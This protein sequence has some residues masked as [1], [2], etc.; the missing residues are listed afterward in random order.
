[1]SAM[2][3]VG[4]LVLGMAATIACVELGAY[5]ATE[6][7]RKSVREHERVSALPRRRW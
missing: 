3:F 6:V 2:D 4:G 7:H 5:Y 1:M